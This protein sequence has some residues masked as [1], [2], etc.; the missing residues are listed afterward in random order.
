MLIVLLVEVVVTESEDVDLWN[1]LMVLVDVCEKRTFRRI[2]LESDDGEESSH[3]GTTDALSVSAIGPLP[4]K[5]SVVFLSKHVQ[6]ANMFP[7][8]ST[9]EHPP[10]NRIDSIISAQLYR[11]TNFRDYCLLVQGRNIEDVYL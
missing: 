2:W 5:P 10:I 11:D 3:T 6:E 8:T 1:M 7:R 4:Q 9:T